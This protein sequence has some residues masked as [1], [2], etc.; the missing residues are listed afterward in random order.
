MK[1]GEKNA[2]LREV[3]EEQELAKYEKLKL[4]GNSTITVKLTD[5]GLDIYKKYVEGTNNLL[6]EYKISDLITDDSFKVNEKG[7]LSLTFYEL[8]TIFG[9]D[10]FKG[11]DLFD[12]ITIESDVS[13]A[14]DG[15]NGKVK[16]IIS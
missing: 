5:R 6:K 12:E 10:T 13:N 16:D 9:G 8:M 14:L 2:Y 3:L 1:S 7:E 4:T 15:V 11:G